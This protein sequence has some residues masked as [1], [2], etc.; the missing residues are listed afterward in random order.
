MTI[1]RKKLL[2]IVSPKNVLNNMITEW[3]INIKSK[4]YANHIDKY[5]LFKSNESIYLFS[6]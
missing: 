4:I 6:I 1:L 3:K 2:P 5:N